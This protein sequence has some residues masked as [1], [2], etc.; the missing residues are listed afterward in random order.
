MDDFFRGR[1]EV[2]KAAAIMK[3]L[4]HPQRLGIAR[5]LARCGGCNVKKIQENTGI[6]QSTISQHLDRL[7]NAGLITGERQGNEVI[8]RLIDPRVK[9]ILQCFFAEEYPE[10]EDR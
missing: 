5:G 8:Y 2:E 10:Q 6:P 1:E 9:T 7:K 3:A 4:G